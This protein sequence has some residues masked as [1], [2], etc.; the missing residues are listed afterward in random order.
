[1]LPFEWREMRR[2]GLS[3]RFLKFLLL[4]FSQAR[5]YRH[6]SGMIYLSDYARDKV[7]A[8][9]GRAAGDSRVIPHGI[10][11]RF[12]TGPK[13]Q[14][15]MEDAKRRV[16]KLLYVSAIDAYKHQWQVVQA[17]EELQRQG[18][19]VELTLVGPSFPEGERKL[20]LAIARFRGAPGSI[21][22]VGAV[23]H[24]DLH[25]YYQDAD[26]FVYASSCEN[27]PNVLLEA[28]ASGTPIA[29]SSRGPMPEVLKDGGVY[30]DPE[31]ASDIASAVRQLLDSPTLR[32]EK[33]ELALRYSRAYSWER[34][35]TESLQYL[36]EV[37]SRHH[38][39]IT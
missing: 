35:A 33:A 17:V 6:S 25:R 14:A 2:F 29:S 30:F 28:M 39:S 20:R 32:R 11:A 16:F 1:M 13:A 3:P 10:D 22:Y 8:V 15:A 19:T 24:E 38:V 23:R 34:C 9:V 18:L 31:K 4:R 21:R 26:I 5:T 7:G 36:A 37:A 12:A 27:L